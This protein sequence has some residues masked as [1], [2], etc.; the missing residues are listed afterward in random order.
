MKS[1]K[2]WTWPILAVLLLAGCDERMAPPTA[3][4]AA[5]ATQEAASAAVCSQTSVGFT[6]LTDPGLIPYPKVPLGLYPGGTNQMPSGHLLAGI[7][8]ASSVTP[9]DASGAPDANGRYALISVGMSNTTNE[10]QKFIALSP[11]PNSRLAMIDGAQGGQTAERW[12]SED[13]ACWDILE[14]RIQ[15]AGL[16]DAQVVAAW[17]KLANAYPAG[18][19]PSAALDLQRDTEAVLRLLGARF[20]NLRLAYLSSRAYGG[21]ATTTL[22]PEP[23][24]YQGGFAMRGVIK[25]QLQGRLPFEGSSR[26][27]PWIAWGPYLWADGLKPRSDGLTWSCGDFLPDGTH[28]SPSGRQKIAELLLKFFTSHQTTHDW[29]MAVFTYSPPR[30]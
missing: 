26:E 5:V 28:P 19:W 2:R 14:E 1:L 9:L 17:I 12:A 29:F 21:Y 10:F 11:S 8:L 4:S 24:A 16:T 15:S 20:P 30:K 3:P 22:N 27:A 18:Q 13:C 25:S 23:Y 7:Q 6:P